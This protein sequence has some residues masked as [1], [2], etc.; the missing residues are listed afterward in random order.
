MILIRITPSTNC[1]CDN[2]TRPIFIGESRSQNTY[3]GD[4]FCSHCIDDMKHGE[5][6]IYDDEIV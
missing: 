4:I 6:Y 1:E 2:C 3:N 5:E